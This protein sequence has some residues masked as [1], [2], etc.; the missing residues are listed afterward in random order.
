MSNLIVLKPRVSEKSYALSQTDG[1]YVFSVPKSANKMTVKKAVELQF[2][3]KVTD[4]RIAHLPPKPKRSVRA[5]GRKVSK[6][7]QP[8]VKKAYVTLKDGESIPIF[9]AEDEEK[10]RTEK[11]QKQLAKG[12]K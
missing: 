7:F 1:V 11:L 4:V 5:G 3:V 6:G 12:K 10:A 8:G 9:A 2:E